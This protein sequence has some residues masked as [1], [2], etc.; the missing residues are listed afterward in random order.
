MTKITQRIFVL[1]WLSLFSSLVLAQQA[2]TSAP[3]VMDQQQL[4]SIVRDFADNAK[5]G[6]GVVEFVYNNVPMAMLSNAE[7]D[8]M[9]IVAPI[10]RYQ[11]LSRPEI[12]AALA[13]NY[14]R[15]LDARYALSD[16][17][18]YSVYI[19][20][21][22]SMNEVQLRSAIFQVSNLALSFGDQFSSGV[23]D[24]GAAQ[25]QNPQN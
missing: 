1:A 11:E 9:R 23:L 5:G 22:S 14:H 12:D 13:A 16:G 25:N 17:V 24:F 15:A 21:L 7:F 19:H 4:E 2:E 6:G 10:I 3:E 18:L 8:R 20:P